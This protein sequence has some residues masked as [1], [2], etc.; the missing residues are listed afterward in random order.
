MLCIMLYTG[1]AAYEPGFLGPLKNVTVVQVICFL[2]LFIYLELNNL[3][4]DLIIIGKRCVLYMHGE[5]M[6][7]H[8]S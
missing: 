1:Q 6:P 3:T 8:Y 4:I 7:F 2:L 5:K